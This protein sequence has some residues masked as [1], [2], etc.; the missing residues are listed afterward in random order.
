MKTLYVTDLDGTLLDNNQNIPTNSANIIN[1]LISKGVLFTY[2]TA[3][4]FYT[5]KKVTY[6]LNINLPVITNNGVS[7][8][9]PNSGEII[10]DI[11][12]K[13]IF[14]RELKK[15]IETLRIF[16]IIYSR[17]GSKET[18]SWLI[19]NLS[20]AIVEYLNQPT[21]QQDPRLCPVNTIDDLLSGNIYY[22]IW[23]GTYEEILPIILAIQNNK[24]CRYIFE[25][26]QNGPY[27]WLEVMPIGA[28]KANAILAL[29]NAIG[30]DQI[31]CFG[32]GAND[33]HMFEIADYSYAVSN[34]TAQLKAIATD[35]IL[36]NEQ[37]GVALWL[38]ENI[39]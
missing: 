18:C 11:S 14:L 7:L 27:Y 17:K 21:R 22:V 36:S 26:Q 10:I 23:M 30:C 25:K 1:D 19:Q 12:F 16:P 4:S 6:N 39:R 31:V 8:V 5:A 33:C 32:D 28:T 9:H 15:L 35:V 34:A 20:P 2:A 37:E 38:K 29:K 3:R 24:D 13:T